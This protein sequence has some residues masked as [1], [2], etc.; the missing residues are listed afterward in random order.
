M[1]DSAGGKSAVLRGKYELASEYGSVRCWKEKIKM[2]NEK[3][4]EEEV[5]SKSTLKWYTLAKNGAGVE[6]YWSV[7]SQEVVRACCS[8]CGLAQ[9]GCWRIRR[10]VK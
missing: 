5:S 3:D 9:L 10:D 6:R 4:C 8:D 1:E 2:R 7:Q